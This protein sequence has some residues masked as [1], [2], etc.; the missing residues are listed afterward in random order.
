[1][2]PFSIMLTNVLPLLII[3]IIKNMFNKGEKGLHYYSMYS[4]T[5]NID[6]DDVKLC[7]SFFFC[8]IFIMVNAAKYNM[9]SKI[10]R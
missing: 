2:Y 5:M 4:Y 8:L 1:M 10:N 7:T 9:F 6:D 3:I